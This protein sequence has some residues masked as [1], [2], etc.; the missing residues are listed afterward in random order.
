MRPEEQISGAKQE[1][2]LPEA[3]TGG[4]TLNQATTQSE[5]LPNS[6]LLLT[7]L[8]LVR[9]APASFSWYLAPEEVQRAKRAAGL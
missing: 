9:S 5:E 1:K 7:N 4:K 8:V 2:L 6:E 3:K